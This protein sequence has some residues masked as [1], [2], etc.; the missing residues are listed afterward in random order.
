MRP[1]L[2]AST[3]DLIDLAKGHWGD[4]DVLAQLLMEANHR[5]SKRAGMLERDLEKRIAYLATR[6]KEARGSRTGESTD[7]QL[8][9]A[10][11]RIV[12]L[13]RELV[14]TRTAGKSEADTARKMGAGEFLPPVHI[15]AGKAR[16]AQ[17]PPPG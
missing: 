3:A 11:A 13:E 10:K 14:A 9:E 4:P 2:T 6:P 5:K 8:A 1:Y 16:L 12:E 17:K 15:R 7:L